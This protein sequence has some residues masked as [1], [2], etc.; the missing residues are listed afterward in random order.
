MYQKASWV[1]KFSCEELKLS[2]IHWVENIYWVLT[3]GQFL[4]K[5]FI[6]MR[7]LIWKRDLSSIYRWGNWITSHS[8]QA[9][10][11]TFEDKQSCSRECIF[12]YHELMISTRRK[13]VVWRNILGSDGGKI[14]VVFQPCREKCPCS[15]IYNEAERVAGLG[16]DSVLWHS[17]QASWKWWWVIY[18]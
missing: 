8:L 5:C 15:E 13:Q 4:F 10:G 12:N 18:F 17:G 2:F 6:W 11:P 7:L 3:M 9:V 1:T 16:S 14:I